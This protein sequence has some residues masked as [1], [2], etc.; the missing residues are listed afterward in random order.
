MRQTV[1]NLHEAKTKRSQLVE[2]APRGETV[3]IARHGEPAV[4]LV[5]VHPKRRPE[6]GAFAGA[7]EL[8]PDFKAPNV[9][10]ER[11][12]E[13]RRG[14]RALLDTWTFVRLIRA[15]ERVPDEKGPFLDRTAGAVE[16]LTIVSPDEAFDRAT[17]G[18][19]TGG[20]GSDDGFGKLSRNTCVVCPIF[21]SSCTGL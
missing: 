13:G 15:P 6:R 10:I 2:R 8:A 4:R 7:I 12:F 3:Y 21:L 17:R 16:A 18:L 5:P 20:R 1:A 19:L 14:V 11:D 9:D